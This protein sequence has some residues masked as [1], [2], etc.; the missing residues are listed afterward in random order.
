M[1]PLSASF[2]VLAVALIISQIGTCD[3]SFDDAPLL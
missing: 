3:G 1:N 2:N